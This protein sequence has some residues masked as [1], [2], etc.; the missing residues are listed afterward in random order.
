MGRFCPY[1]V[2]SSMKK[3]QFM[4]FLSARRVKI[5]G[6]KELICLGLVPIFYLCQRF[7]VPRGA[8]EAR[9][10]GGLAMSGDVQ[11]IVE[12]TVGGLG[13]ELVDFDL[14]ARGLLRVFIDKADGISVEDCANVSNH[15]SRVLAVE[16]IDFE[17]LE[18]SSP[19]LD[20]PLK[21]LEDFQ[22]FVGCGAKVKLNAMIDSRKRFDGVIESAGA[23]GIAFRIIEDPAKT[24]GPGSGAPKISGKVLAKAKGKRAS[25]PASAKLI[26]VP[27]ENIDR[28]R[29]IPEF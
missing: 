26:T 20:R 22:R 8:V 12:S 1:K 6:C 11:A 9:F 18:V 24:A 16:G 7:H 15:L 19:G 17:R 4:W 10:L 13:Y 27:I 28:A 5:Y 2:G 14:S 23:G 3:R 25:E 21:K 29:L